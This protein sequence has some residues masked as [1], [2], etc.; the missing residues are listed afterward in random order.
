[1]ETL[2][3]NEAQETPAANSFPSSVSAQPQPQNESFGYLVK[4]STK[5]QAAFIVGFIIICLIIVGSVYALTQMV[6]KQTTPTVTPTASTADTSPSDTS[7]LS[8][9]Y[10]EVLGIYLKLPQDWECKTTGEDTSV[11]ADQMDGSIEVKSTLFTIIMSN[12]GRGGPCDNGS[13]VDAEKCT[14]KE[15]FRS[16]VVS[17]DSFMWE[18]KFQEIFG[19]IDRRDF[20]GI[21]TNESFVA[22][23]SVTYIGSASGELTDKNDINLLKSVLATIRLEESLPIE[24]DADMSGRNYDYEIIQ[25][26]PAGSGAPGFVVFDKDDP[27]YRVVVNTPDC[28]VVN[29]IM[30]PDQKSLAFICDYVLNVMETNNTLFNDIFVYNF[31]TG[32]LNRLTDQVYWKSKLEELLKEG[33]DTSK[34]VEHGYANDFYVDLFW[35]K[36]ETRLLTVMNRD[37]L[38]VSGGVTLFPQELGV[39]NWYTYYYRP[40]IQLGKVEG[41]DENVVS[42]ADD[43]TKII[44]SY[45]LEGEKRSQTYNVQ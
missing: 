1:M 17:V 6:G 42:Y 35:N 18:G 4:K 22:W 39:Y 2:P 38:I 10:S 20:A 13:D 34:W 31:R 7:D 30:S 21:T 27:N 43:Y 29:E 33:A 14:Q 36:A 11:N 15:L 28:Y 40:E 12:L 26:P 16:N 32:L 3:L 9:C 8:G 5:Q 45:T 44:V 25:P 37:T 24:D 19:S 41:R 23:V